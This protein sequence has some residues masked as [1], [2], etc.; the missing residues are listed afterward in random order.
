M[1]NQ[2]SIVRTNKRSPK[3]NPPLPRENINSL[4]QHHA[5]AEHHKMS[6]LPNL[7][8]RIYINLSNLKAFKKDLCSHF[9]FTNTESYANFFH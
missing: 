1:K 4:N 7:S 5:T 8:L 9:M 2:T 3:L 6:L